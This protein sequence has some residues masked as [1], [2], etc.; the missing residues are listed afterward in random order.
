[1][2]LHRSITIY[3]NKNILSVKEHTVMFA[4]K[5]ALTPPTT[6]RR[7]NRGTPPSVAC[8]IENYSK[9]RVLKTKLTD[10]SQVEITLAGLNI[11]D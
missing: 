9:N 3:I 6:Q 1:M 5:C 8:A 2:G 11:I 10:I 7:I 4:S